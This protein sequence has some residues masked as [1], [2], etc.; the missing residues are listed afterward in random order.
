MRK[1]LAINPNDVQLYSQ[2]GQILYRQGKLEQAV[3]VYQ[4]YWQL[5]P[6]KL[7]VYLALGCLHVELGNIDKAAQVFSLGEAVDKNILTTWRGSETNPSLK[8][9]S[10]TAW[11]TLRKHHT[12]LHIKTVEKLGDDKA[13][14]RIRDAVWPLLDEREV[15]YEHQKQNAQVFYIK[16]P[17]TPAFYERKTFPWCE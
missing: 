11:E 6:R 10:K 13:I 16:Y 5:N 1:L 15:N 17:E 12:E 7:L 4:K 9:M 2:L 8:E 3:E 14:N